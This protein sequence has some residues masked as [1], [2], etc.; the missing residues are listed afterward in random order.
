VSRIAVDIVLLP[1]QAMTEWAMAINTELVRQYGSEIVLS[2]KTCLP[3]VS[4]AMGCLDEG[5]IDSV[6]VLLHRLA[7]EAPVRQLNAT[8]ILVS[9]NSRGEHTS[10]LGIERTN[11]LQALH[12]AVMREV[13]PFFSHD[14]IEAM[15]ADDVV[16]ESTLE[17]I[18]DYPQ[19]AAYER[20]S[21]HITLGY[22]QATTNDSFPIPFAVSRLALC[23]VGNHGTCRKVV[24]F[25]SLP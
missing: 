17:W 4:L 18:R 2:E 21:P 3:H 10:L 11:D 19:K 13:E 20:F 7:K 5:D 24:V 9:T 8:G 1:D 23:H 14:V 16:A 6:R 15:I 25:V 12:E 22:G